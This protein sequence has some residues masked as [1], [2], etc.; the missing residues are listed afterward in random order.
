M[1]SDFLGFLVF[2]NLLSMN[3]D[4]DTQLTVMDQAEFPHS[5]CWSPD[6]NMLRVP[7][8]K[9]MKSKVLQNLKFFADVTPLAETFKPGLIW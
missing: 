1:R 8:S 3:E 9:N 6:P 5:I 4:G 7:K 2:K